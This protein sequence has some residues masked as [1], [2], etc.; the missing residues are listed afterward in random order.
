MKVNSIVFDCDGVLIDSE[1]IANRI[2][3]EVKTE[4]GFPITL[5]EQLKK[6]VGLGMSHPVVQAELQRLP[7][8][9]WQMVDDRVK[10]AYINELKAIDGVVEIL[11]QLSLPKCVASSSEPDWLAFKLKHTKLIHH[12]PN[13]IFSGRMVK[14]SKPA[15]DLFLLALE[16]MGW[17]ASGC[18]VV[19]DS[20]AGVE[21]GKAA[22]L[23]V[24]GFT[25]G[26]HIYPGHAE[27]LIAAGAD[28]MISNFSQLKTLLC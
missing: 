14:N 6:F 10:I 21:A 22:G 5:E 17:D 1:I 7:A 13:A 25:G 28:H 9:Y 15:P 11:E 12:F 2:E 24:C 26:A 3:V 19:E 8:D 4:L 27:R 20:V 16:K 23:T 18:L